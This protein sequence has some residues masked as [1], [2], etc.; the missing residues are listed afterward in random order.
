MNEALSLSRNSTAAA[1]SSGVPMRR[2]GVRLDHDFAK[3]ASSRFV[4]SV[5]MAP[6]ATQLTR[7][8]YGPNSNAADL[9][10]ISIPPLLAVYPERLG[11]G[12][13]LH[14]DPMFTIAPQRCS[15]I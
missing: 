1:T 6:G 9:V 13:L 2:K 15:C 7:I 14:P 4:R 8:P 10:N 11:K 3:S 12:T 5:S